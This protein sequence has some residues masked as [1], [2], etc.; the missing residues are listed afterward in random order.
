MAEKKGKDA[1]KCTETIYLQYNG[2]EVCIDAVRAA[3]KE[4]YESVKKGD[5]AAKEIEIYLKPE[6]AKAYYVINSDF[7]GEVDLLLE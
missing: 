4:N 2:K 3:I 5:D 7:A 1:V 6:D